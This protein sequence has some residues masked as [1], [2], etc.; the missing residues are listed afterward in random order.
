MTERTLNDF[1]TPILSGLAPQPAG[2]G[3]LSRDRADDLDAH[4]RMLA[5]ERA[6]AAREL[7][8]GT[9]EVGHG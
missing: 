8:F 3:V 7:A 6:R 2:V 4:L 9:P 1:T 5:V